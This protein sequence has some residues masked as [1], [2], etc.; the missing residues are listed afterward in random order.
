MQFLVIHHDPVFSAGLG[1]TLEHLGAT[2][3]YAANGRLGLRLAASRSFDA[4][5]L[6]AE[7]PRS[8]GLQ[9]CRV[10]REVLDA[11]TPI[12]MVG[13]RA[14]V[15]ATVAAMAAGADDYRTQPVVYA[16][17][18]ARLRALCRRCRSST[19][20]E[21]ADLQFD[22]ATEAVYREGKRL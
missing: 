5:V 16:E 10:L 8:D 4:I 22:P 1:D 17:V 18:H 14:G 7:L 12:M 13:C 6:A 19:T 20:L 21:V 3:D 2:V 9:I 15:E 11:S